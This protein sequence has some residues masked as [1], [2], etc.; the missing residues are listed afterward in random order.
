MNPK[1]RETRNQKPETLFLILCL[2]LLP[3][4]HAHAQQSR[5]NILFIMADDHAVNAMAN[6]NSVLAPY[7]QTDR[8]EEIGDEGMHFANAFVTNSICTPSRATILTGQY[9]HKNDVFILGEPLN[10][11]Q[12]TVATIMND[13]GYET[14]VYGKWHLLTDPVGFDDYKVLRVQGRYHDPSFNVKGEDEDVVS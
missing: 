7:A 1:Q 12:P 13:A 9:S 8:I 10:Q 4:L 3:Y 5:P 2:L 14:A 6:G 11:E